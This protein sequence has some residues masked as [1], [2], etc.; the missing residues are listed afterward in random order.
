MHR[1]KKMQVELLRPGVRGLLALANANNGDNAG[2]FALNANNA[3]SN[4]NVNYGAFLNSRNT[5]RR[6]EVSLPDWGNINKMMTSLQ[7]LAY[8]SVFDRRNKIQLT[9]QDPD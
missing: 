9:P 8:S 4:A 1:I 5:L 6:Y 3:P 7:M 2:S